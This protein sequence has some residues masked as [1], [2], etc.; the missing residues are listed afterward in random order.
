MRHLVFG[1]VFVRPAWGLRPAA[2]GAR[3]HSGRGPAGQGRHARSK[4]S[5]A[6][7]WPSCCA[8]RKIP[9]AHAA[10][11]AG[12]CSI[13]RASFRFLPLRYEFLF[14]NQAARTRSHG[15]DASLQ[16]TRATTPGPLFSRLVR[17]HSVSRMGHS[18]ADHPAP[19]GPAR[20]APSSYYTRLPRNAKRKVS[21]IR[22]NLP[23]LCDTGIR[24]LA[25][26][27]RGRA[28]S[29][30]VCWWC[31]IIAPP[32]QARWGRGPGAGGNRQ[33]ACC[34]RAASALSCERT[35]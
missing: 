32:R 34:G 15:A 12:G 9:C 26:A 13:Q 10:R 19:R 6:P 8:D 23:M 3:D 21:G 2:A 17:P 24:P 16:K 22:D 33:A 35:L 5:L 7:G 30:L 11:L 31:R 20:I 29:L 14:L 4:R 18:L 25:G 28:G 27:G 1:L